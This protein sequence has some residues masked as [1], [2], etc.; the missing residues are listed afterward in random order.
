[1]LPVLCWM[2]TTRYNCN[3]SL[4]PKHTSGGLMAD[5][6][7]LDHLW[8]GYWDFPDGVQTTL[9]M[10][11]SNMS[12]RVAFDGQSMNDEYMCS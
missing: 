3:R 2:T 8:D 9:Q 5:V 12:D 4:P 7:C 10:E 1:M 11:P 6:P